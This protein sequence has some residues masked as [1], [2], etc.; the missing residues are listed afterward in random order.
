MRRSL[1]P[2][3]WP[4]RLTPRTNSFSGIPDGRGRVTPAAR[5]AALVCGLP[6]SPILLVL[7]FV[8][9]TSATA[10][11]NCRLAAIGE[12]SVR[13]ASDGRTVLLADGR[14]VRLAGIEVAAS[15][16][17]HDAAKA[18]LAGLVVGRTVSLMR[19]GAE[20]NRYGRIAAQVYWADAPDEPSMQRAL[21]AQGHAKVAARVG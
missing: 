14:E 10:Q 11:A 17:E 2:P 7:A 13:S 6:S 18:A 12:G 5:K 4:K 19:P 1:P 9:A 21:L 16:P 8:C 15:G 20:A 3:I